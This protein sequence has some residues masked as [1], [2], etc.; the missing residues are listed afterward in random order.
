M[1]TTGEFPDVWNMEAV[2][3]VFTIGFNVIFFF[4]MLNFVLAIREKSHQSLSLHQEGQAKLAYK[5]EHWHVYTNGPKPGHT[6][7]LW[8]AFSESRRILRCLACIHR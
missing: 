8:R 6:Q 2:L 1:M 7:P 3:G 5:C 4:C